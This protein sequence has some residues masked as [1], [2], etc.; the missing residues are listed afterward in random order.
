[1]IEAGKYYK[2]KVTRKTDL[3]FMLNDGEV[4]V[5][6][7]YRQSEKE[8]EVND[9]LSAFI[10]YDKEGR[11]CATDKQVHAT[12]QKP[13]LVEVVE[14]ND[15]GLFID[16]N[17]SKDVLLSKDYLPYNHKLWPEVGDKIYITLKNKNRISGNNIN[18]ESKSS[19]VAKL[20]NKDTCLKFKTGNYAEGEVVSAIVSVINS[21]G[22]GLITENYNYIF[23]PTIMT[24]G[25]YHLGQKVDVKITKVTATDIYGTLIKQKEEQM[26]S[27]AQI[28]LDYLKA[29]KGFMPYTAKSSSDVIELEFKMSR[30][31][32][33][34][35]YGDL[36]KERKI[37]FDEKGTWLNEND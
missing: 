27:D 13:G 33:K 4:E 29:H 25:T 31:A 21:G 16:N 11:M 30:K 8:Y 35:A 37:Y 7:H 14:V 10:Y 1:M 34:R 12:T 20:I 2:F 32:F 26:D 5:L 23:V 18:K 6:M 24:R 19:L 3:G 28:I 22:Y 36:Y 15:S 9:S 17:T